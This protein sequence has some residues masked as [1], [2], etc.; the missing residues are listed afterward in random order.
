MELKNVSRYF[1]SE[2]KYGSSVIYFQ[3]EDGKDF[4]DSLNKFT[5]R[6]KLCIESDSGI[7]RSCS[8]DVSTLY[9]GGFSLVEC[10][11]LPDGFDIHGGWQYK[12]ESIYAVSETDLSQ[13]R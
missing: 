13:V 1:P 3:S 9:P 10:D 11:E 5:K 4:Y 8:E 6:Y 2:M 7:I 12:N